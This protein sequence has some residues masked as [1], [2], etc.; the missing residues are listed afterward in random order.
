MKNYV[1]KIKHNF[2]KHPELL[3]SYGFNPYQAEGEEEIIYA[4]PIVLKEDSSIFQYLKK[5]FEKV[6]A[7][8]TDEEKERDFKN[9]N[10]TSKT[11]K[12]ILTKA[13]RKEFSE[14]Q[15]CFANDGLGAWTLFINA[16]DRVE[17]Y[18]TVVLDEC[19]KD[20]IDKFLKDKVIYKASAIKQ[21]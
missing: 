4:L 12:L 21:K 17:Y 11:H 13:I 19:I 1:Y 8:A 10:F 15:L 18:N 7:K 9:Y 6:H 14:C 20:I 2:K 5:A 16:P 3:A